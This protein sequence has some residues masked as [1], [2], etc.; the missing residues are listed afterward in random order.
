[1]TSVEGQKTPEDF[2]QMLRQLRNWE[3]WGAEDQRGAINLVT[4]E[5]T[6]AAAGLIRTG[7]TVSMSR[8]FPKQPAPNNQ[9]PAHHVVWTKDYPDSEDGAQVGLDFLTL[10]VHGQA[11][12]HLD[13]LSHL[14]NVDGMWNGRQ[15][16]AEMAGDGV[17]WGGI[18]QWR[19]GIATRGVLL[20]VAAH[21]DVGFVE[22][23]EPVSAEELRE[24]ARASA[25]EPASGDA[26][27]IHCGREGWERENGESWG[28]S[29]EGVASARRPGLAASCLEYF[30]ESD[31]SVIIWDM[32]D[33]LPNEY[34]VRHT[35]HAALFNQGVALLDNA[36]LE[37]LA[38]A[39]RAAQRFEFFVVV[40]PLP[41]E[42]A[43]GSPVNPLAIL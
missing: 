38:E 10:A 16:R 23:D 8:P 33:A 4:E 17:R 6:R 18:E 40:A 39:C 15:A 42:G 20:D 31:C 27:V 13:A 26:L 30:Y 14:W 1:M 34:G 32:M 9:R 5:K 35:T 11:S 2:L 25:I 36:L 3:R 43:T 24:I 28:S 21:R 29:S 19:D 7:T 22:L 37:P 41:I 12:T